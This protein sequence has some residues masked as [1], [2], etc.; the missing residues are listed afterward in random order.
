M[1]Q[2]VVDTHEYEDCARGPAGP[3]LEWTN[4]VVCLADAFSAQAKENGKH[5]HR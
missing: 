1:R 4:L 5:E 2:A 3:L